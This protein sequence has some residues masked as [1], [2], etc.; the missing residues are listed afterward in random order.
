MENED[1][2]GTKCPETR[3]EA[4]GLK[5]IFHHS[6]KEKI[7]RFSHLGSVDMHLLL[8]TGRL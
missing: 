8:S 4:S 6:L 2:L 7:P 5:A 3:R 1:K